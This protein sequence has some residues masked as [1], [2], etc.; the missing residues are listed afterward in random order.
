MSHYTRDESNVA[1]SKFIDLNYAEM[2]NSKNICATCKAFKLCNKAFLD[3]GLFSK[4]DKILT[5]LNK[6]ADSKHAETVEYFSDDEI[7][8]AYKKYRKSLLFK[9]YIES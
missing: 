4:A 1:L 6:S 2:D 3:A 9:A 5:Q 7:N 8:K